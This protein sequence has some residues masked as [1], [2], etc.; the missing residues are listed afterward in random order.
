[1]QLSSELKREVGRI[2]ATQYR[3]RISRYRRQAFYNSKP[4]GFE[5]WFLVCLRKCE[6]RGAEFDFLCPGLVRITWPEKVPVLRI[7]ADFER[8]YENEYLSKF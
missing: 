8:E 5:T 4:V 7:L 6:K 2:K 3:Q 1:M